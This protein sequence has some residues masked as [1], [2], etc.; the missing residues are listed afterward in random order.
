MPEWNFGVRELRPC[1]AERKRA[2]LGAVP[3]FIYIEREVQEHPRTQSIL[4]RFPDAKAVLIDRYG[5]IFNKAQQD[6]RLQKQR[7]ALILARKHDNFVLPAPAGYGIGSRQNYYFSHLLNCPYDC[8][9]C[10]LQGMYRSAH[11]LLFVNYED[12]QQEIRSIAQKEPSTCFF[13]GYD[14]DSLALE[15][16]THFSRE[17]LPLFASLPQ[18]L[19][20]LRTKSTH[21]AAL[22]DQA[23]LDN[24]IVA[25]SLTPEEIALEHEHRTPKLSKRIAAAAS[26]A[27]AGW[28]IGLRLDPIIYDPNLP[29]QYQK[30]LDDIFEKISP[31]SIHSVSAGPLRFPK[32]VH[33]KISRLYPREALLAGPLAE[34]PGPGS[35]NMVSYPLE[36]EREMHAIVLDLVQ[37]H[38]PPSVVFSCTP[39][40][41]Q[42]NA[43]LG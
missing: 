24:V 10:F 4:A 17:F 33:R 20:E 18:A 3:D 26:L 16:I 28:R 29:K 25:L 23:P 5:E 8:R 12:F 1:E 39:Q 34:H 40:S 27:R 21:T 19:F 38:L 36:L 14:C 7:P 41:W 11:H 31:E 35:K 42:D 2:L 37:R 9:Y 22:I 6:F 30:L 13:S 32:T 43:Q 15:P